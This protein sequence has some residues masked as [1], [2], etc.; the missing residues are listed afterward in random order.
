MVPCNCDRR[1]NLN[2]LMSQLSSL[3]YHAPWFLMA[4][5][6][7]VPDCA[8][9]LRTFGLKTRNPSRNGVPGSLPILFIRS[10]FSDISGHASC[11]PTTLYDSCEP[12]PCCHVR[13]GW[14]C[15]CR[16]CRFSEISSLC[17]QRGRLCDE[18]R[19]KQ[20]QDHWRRIL[21]CPMFQSQESD[22]RLSSS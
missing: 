7:T 17:Y 12:L 19:S 9:D 5:G 20:R 21:L 15:H 16:C 22:S 6:V 18:I 3:L 2:N 8:L 10:L 1:S 14:L 13:Y 11:A 4:S